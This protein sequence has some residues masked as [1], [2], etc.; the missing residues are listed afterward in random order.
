MVLCDC[1]FVGNNIHV[2]LM[3]SIIIYK[4]V[5]QELLQPIIDDSIQGESIFDELHRA[6]EALFMGMMIIENKLGNKNTAVFDGALILQLSV[7]KTLSCYHFSARL[8][9]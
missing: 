5:D 2:A 3:K 7:I 1:T 8:I 6:R 4:L 9:M